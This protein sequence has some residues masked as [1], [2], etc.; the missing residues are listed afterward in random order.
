ML[1]CGV[2]II[3]DDCGLALIGRDAKHNASLAFDEIVVAESTDVRGES[4]H[5]AGLA[6]SPANDG[7]Q[8]FHTL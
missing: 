2:A 8:F 1:E 3:E 6:P 7:D 4:C 5:R